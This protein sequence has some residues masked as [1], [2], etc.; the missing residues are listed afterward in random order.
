M[1]QMNI[2]SSIDI[3]SNFSAIGVKQCVIEHMVENV[4]ST[5]VALIPTCKI[6]NVQNLYPIWFY[7]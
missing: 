3:F 2:I 5:N 7:L 1:I 6:D 4:M